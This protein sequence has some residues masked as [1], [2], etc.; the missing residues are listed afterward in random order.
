MEITNIEFHKKTL[1]KAGV[2]FDLGLSE[3]EI[4][5]VENFYNRPLAK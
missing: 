3:E 2:V 1:E 5:H 4:L